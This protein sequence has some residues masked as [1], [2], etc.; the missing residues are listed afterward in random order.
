MVSSGVLNP[1]TP[2]QDPHLAAKQCWTWF[3]KSYPACPF[4]CAYFHRLQGSKSPAPRAQRVF[5]APRQFSSLELSLLIGVLRRDLTEARKLSR[6]E[7][8]GPRQAY[9]S[10]SLLV[11]AAQRH[12]T[13]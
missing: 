8:F 6:R 13:C 2:N 9:H 3:P 5:L 4:L 11:S 10:S 12:L 1:L 7:Q